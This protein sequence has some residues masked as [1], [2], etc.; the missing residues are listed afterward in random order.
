MEREWLETIVGLPEDLEYCDFVTEGTRYVREL[1]EAGADIVIALTHMRMPN[2]Q[3]LAESVPG[4]DL[5]LGGHDHFY[6]W[7]ESLPKKTGRQNL[8]AKHMLCEAFAA[9]FF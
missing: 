6:N 5:I 1:R 7:V 2:D 8:G 3:R 9:E 4:I